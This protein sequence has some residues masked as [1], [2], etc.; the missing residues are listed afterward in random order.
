MVHAFSSHDGVEVRAS[1]AASVLVGHETF[2]LCWVQLLVSIMN[3]AVITQPDSA[4]IPENIS[5]LAAVPGV[6]LKSIIIL[7][8][9]S[10]LANKRSYFLRGFGVWQCCGLFVR[11]MGRRVSAGVRRI[12]GLGVRPGE[13]LSVRQVAADLGI[14]CQ[15]TSELHTA[16]ILSLLASLDLDLVVSFSA[17]IVFQE[18]LLSL[19]RRGCINLHCSLLPRYAGLLPRFWVLYH[20]EATTGATV[21]FMDTRIDNGGILGQETVPIR[22]GATMLDVIRA[23]KRVGGDLMARVVGEVAAGTCTVRDNRADK[24]AY[25]G[26]PTVEQMRRFRREGGRLA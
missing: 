13:G 10:A 11:L 23:T 8:V 18:Q 21:H 19:P 3:I 17:P 26:W 5:K 12:T 6:I 4:V 1:S 7:D 24:G 22:A 15:E 20:H 9:K 16:Q 2:E 25:F 14:P